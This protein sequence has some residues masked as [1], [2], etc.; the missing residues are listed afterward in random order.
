MDIEYVI[1]KSGALL[2]RSPILIRTNQDKVL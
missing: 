2:E 1:E